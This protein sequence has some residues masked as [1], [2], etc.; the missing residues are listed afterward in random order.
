MDGVMSRSGGIWGIPAV[1]AAMTGL[2]TALLVAFRHTGAVAHSP[3]VTWW[4]LAGLSGLAEVFVVH[5]PTSKNAHTHSVRELPTVLGLAFLSPV[6]YVAAQVVGG[7]AALVLHR[8]QRGIKLAFNLA[9]FAV[10]A[11]L[12]VVAYRALLGG[13][14]P[15]EPRGWLAALG[16]AVITDLVGAGLVT[17][18]IALQEHAFDRPVLREAV[19]RGVLAA[20]ANTCL[21]SLLVVLLVREPRALPLLLAVLLVLYV[22]YR[23]YVTLWVGYERLQ[24]LYRFVRGAGMSV[25]PDEAVHTVLAEAREL[26]RAS[27]AEL[28]MLASDGPA[29]TCLALHDGSDEV[30]QSVLAGSEDSFWWRRAVDDEIVYDP[31]VEPGGGI[32]APVHSRDAVVGVLLVTGRTVE[33]E[34]FSAEDARL[35]GTLAAHASV[36]LENARLVDR[37]RRVAAEREYQALHDSLTGL[38]NRLLIRRQLAAAV[39]GGE[40]AVVVIGLDDI[41]RVN[42]VLGHASGESLVWLIADRLRGLF[43]EAVGRLE[44]DEFAILLPDQCADRAAELAHRLL[45]TLTQQLRLGDV[46]VYVSGRAGIAIA[47]QDATDPDVLLRYASAAMHTADSAGDPVAHH[48]ETAIEAGERRLALATDLSCAL[49]EGGLERWYQPQADASSKD[50]FGVEALLRW[51]HPLYS[52]VPP[53]E[54]IAVAERTGQLSGLTDFTFRTAL[55]Q[56]AAWAEDGLDLVLSVNVTARDVH[57]PELPARVARQ[58]AESGTPPYRLVIEITESGVM[59]D[60]ERALVVLHELVSL[61]VRLSID[62][63]GTGYSSLAYLERLPAHEVKVDRSFVTRLAERESDSAVVRSTVSLAHELGLRVVAEGVES[64]LAWER[65]TALGCDAVQGYVLARP[66]PAAALTSWLADRRP[67][68]RG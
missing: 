55:A 45:A 30:H 34:P 40:V 65:V 62:D 57:D 6:G 27:H 10:E 51:R 59:T 41:D 9:W 50:V 1:I 31:H 3:W 35:F 61:G 52:Y 49:V 32:A 7:G 28:L 15:A 5:L 39:Q 4:L 14:S 19:T 17:A 64:W 8:R 33:V 43:G 23:A 53:D 37:L 36:A 68:L 18:A 48:S 66:M 44:G 38:P 24:L 16:A 47:P 54:L 11:L 21:A 13:A 67:A 58:L 2:S 25:E 20:S 46:P 60:P 22:A 42:E 63:F 12:G 56:R 26:M 29:G